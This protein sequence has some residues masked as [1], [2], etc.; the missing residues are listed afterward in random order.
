MME[1]VSTFEESVNF[2]QATRRNITE[3]SRLPKTSR[4]ALLL[5][6]ADSIVS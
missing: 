5:S 4:K 6:T 1:T 3:D 2:Y